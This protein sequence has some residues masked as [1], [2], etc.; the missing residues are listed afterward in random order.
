MAPLAWNKYI[1]HNFNNVN[2]KQGLPLETEYLNKIK[3]ICKDMDNVVEGF[4]VFSPN[5]LIAISHIEHHSCQ[6]L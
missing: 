4:S 3:W 6:E 1:V 2:K 5:I